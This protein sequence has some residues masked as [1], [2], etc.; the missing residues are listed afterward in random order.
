VTQKINL[1]TLREVPVPTPP[2]AEQRQISSVLAT[3]DEK[4]D[5]NRRICEQ[6]E[7]LGSHLVE[8]AVRANE[9]RSDLRLG[10]IIEVLETG[11]RPRGGVKDCLD[12]VPSI[13]AEGVIGIGRFDFSK[14]RFVSRDFFRKMRRGRLVDRDILIYKDGAGIGAS[15]LV[16]EGFPFSE[17]CINEHVFRLRVRPPYSQELL[18]FVLRQANVVDE[19]R[20]RATGAAIPGLNQ[21][22]VRDVRIPALHASALDQLRDVVTLIATRILTASTETRQLADLRNELVPRLVTGL[23]RVRVAAT[24]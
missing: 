17:A 20:R 6:L 8:Q 23:I 5:H 11:S 18:Y 13:G 15:T 9:R 21:T 12:G 14:T 19:L 16:G 7:R 3:L 22:A 24:P 1:S 4:I 10:E 2:L